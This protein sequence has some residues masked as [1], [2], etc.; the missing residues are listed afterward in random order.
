MTKYVNVYVCGNHETL[1]DGTIQDGERY[2]DEIS[3][4]IS[5]VCN[6]IDD[7]NV[8]EVYE[9]DEDEDGNK[10]PDERRC[11]SEVKSF[12][13]DWHGGRFYMKGWVCTLENDPS[14]KLVEMIEQANQKFSD[15]ISAIGEQEDD[16]VADAEMEDLVDALEEAF[17]NISASEFFR[18]LKR[19]NGPLFSQITDSIRRIENATH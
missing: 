9:D 14:P 3:D 11:V 18:Y 1:A 5:E 15:L 16:D 7:A 10:T 8:Y 4:A 19:N 17:G 2:S 13:A 12:F 6:F